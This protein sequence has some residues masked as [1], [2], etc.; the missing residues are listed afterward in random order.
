MFIFSIVLNPKAMADGF[1]TNVVKCRF[2]YVVTNS[3]Q[4]VKVEELIS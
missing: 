4:V 2:L 1:R 3:L